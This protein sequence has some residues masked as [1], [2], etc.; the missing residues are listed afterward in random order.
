M[1]EMETT[2][3]PTSFEKKWYQHWTERGFF[4]APTG[5]AKKPYTILMP[6]PNVTS[7]LHMGHGS[8]YTIQDILVRW[9]R[10]KGFNALWLP[11]TD[12]A[13]I[14][15]QMMVEKAL[16]SE[17]GKTRQQVGRDGML[18]RLHAWKA[19]Y[20][21]II[22]EQFR[23][24]GFSC[25]WDREAYTMDPQLS[26]AV[27][28]IFVQLYNEGLVYR[29]QRLVNWDPALKTAISDDEIE[30]I[31]MNATLW[32]FNY[33]IHESPGEFIPIATTRPETMLGDTAVAVNPDDERYKHLVG[34]QVKLPF[35]ERLIPIIADGYVAADFGTGCVKIT[36][37]HDFNDFEMGKRHKLPMI[38]V[39]N[40]DGTMSDQCPQRFRGLDRFL[41]RKDIVKGMK[42]LGLF[43]KDE[44]HRNAVP[45]SDRSKAVIEPRLSMQWF[46][47]MKELAAPAIQVAKSGE[48]SFHPDLWKKTYLHW[49]ENIQDW[50][51]SRQ[52]WWGHRIPI[53]YCQHCQAVTTG[54]EDPTK[55]GSCGSADIR[56]DED[57]LDTWFSSWLWPISPFGW[58]EKT[59]DLQYF[60]PTDTLV[61]ANEILFLWVARMVMIGLKTQGRVP[62]KHVYMAPTICDKQGRKFSKTLGNGID[63]LDVIEKHGTD[64]LRLGVSIAPFGG[65]VRMEFNDFEHSAR[66][67]NKLWNSAR[68]LMRYTSQDAKLEPLNPNQMDLASKWLVEEFARTADDV[69]H[70][71]SQFRINEAINRMYQFT[72]GSFCDWGLEC[73]KEALNGSDEKA[74]AQ[75]VSVLVY[76]LE[77]VLR[78]FS[79]VMP[80]ICEELWHR[81]PSHPAWPRAESLMIS[82]YPDGSKLTRFKEAGDSWAMVQE[83]ITGIRSTRALAQINPKDPLTVKMRAD[84][85]L[86]KIVMDVAHLIKRLA[87]VGDI[88]AAPDVKRPGQ[89]LVTIGKGFEAYIPATGLIDVVA[90]KK[91]L[92]SERDRVTKIL[93]GLK[94]KLENPNF[95][96]RAPEDVVQQTKDQFANMTS[97]LKSLEQ[98]LEALA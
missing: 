79:P 36:P 26:R 48:L 25:D 40:D 64:A 70:L 15:T 78:F 27:R 97:Q 80:F 29:G 92:S 11:G 6:P 24:L 95:A 30:T 93:S 55:C 5:S 18:E 67:V 85:N 14:A 51:I 74:K 54:M 49:L 65:R 71:L 33:P 46:V 60:Y 82:D 77:G 42:E 75:T 39:M 23:S 81:L 9:K 41:A 68:F 4:K 98:N 31:E 66:F 86:T 83:L 76:V 35:S 61:S 96:D 32:H 43:I 52:I 73:A 38:N 56:Q 10:M 3:N 13:G 53:W 62:F 8:T 63:P 59:K 84:A 2:Y 17:E 90:E 1:S 7:Q 69:D 50:C 20:G 57:V 22:T 89:S 72:W 58:P 34:K 19:K 16:E 91:R 12:H 21:G 87:T 37:A 44:T 28:A 94:S 88:H 45:H 47:K